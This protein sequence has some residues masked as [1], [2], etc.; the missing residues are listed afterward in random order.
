[1]YMD[2]IITKMIIRK[3]MSFFMTQALTI[4]LVFCLD[5]LPELYNSGSS[6]LFCLLLS[7]RTI[8]LP[9]FLNTSL[10]SERSFQEFPPTL[11]LIG[12]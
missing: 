3:E 6:Y 8:V 12:P 10:C 1:M 7:L 11:F 9:V 4:S 5:L 2:Y